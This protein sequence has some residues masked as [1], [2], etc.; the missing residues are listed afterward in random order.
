MSQR[1]AADVPGE[2]L[3]ARDVSVSLGGRSILDGVG[4]RVETGEIVGLIGANGAGKTTLLR[5]L[6]GVLRPTSGDVRRPRRG[7]DR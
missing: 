1:P 4:L 2:V 7:A 3:S 5:V 6:L